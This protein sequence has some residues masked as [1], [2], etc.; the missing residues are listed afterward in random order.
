MGTVADVLDKGS[1]ALVLLDGEFDQVFHHM[2][3][4]FAYLFFFRHPFNVSFLK[5]S[6]PAELLKVNLHVSAGTEIMD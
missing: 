3:I 2:S 1:G 6:S 4:S 5:V